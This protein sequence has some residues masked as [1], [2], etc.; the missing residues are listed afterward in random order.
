M[1]M[2]EVMLDWPQQRRSWRPMR[3]LGNQILHEWLGGVNIEAYH[4]NG[5]VSLYLRRLMR[6]WEAEVDA[7]AALGS[8]EYSGG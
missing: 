3:R 7:W 1:R 5:M 8:R 6:A 2:I 4:I